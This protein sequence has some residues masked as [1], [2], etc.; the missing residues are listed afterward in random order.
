MYKSASGKDKHKP[1]IFRQQFVALGSDD[2][3]EKKKKKKNAWMIHVQ[4]LSVTAEEIGKAE[5]RGDN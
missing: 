2:K 4:V 3:N 1:C 5:R